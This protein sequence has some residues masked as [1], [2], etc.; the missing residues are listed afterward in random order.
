MVQGT[1]THC[2]A[3][4]AVSNAIIAMKRFRHR[5]GGVE[6]GAS[7]VSKMG[8]VKVGGSFSPRMGRLEAG[9]SFLPR[10]G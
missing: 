6:A 8:Q 3:S 10:M 2:T 9:G 7:F 4:S 1:Q 5:M